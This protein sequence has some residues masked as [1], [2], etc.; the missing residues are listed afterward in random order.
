MEELLLMIQLAYWKAQLLKYLLELKLDE[1]ITNDNNQVSDSVLWDT[2]KAV[3]RGHIIFIHFSFF[4]SLSNVIYFKMAD[5]LCKGKLF[6]I[7]ERKI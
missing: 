3:M 5:S 6:F 7:K 4:I 1:F 2:L